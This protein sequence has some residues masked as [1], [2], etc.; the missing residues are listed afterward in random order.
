MRYVAH[1]GVKLQ[2]DAPAYE[3]GKW[4]TIKSLEKIEYKWRLNANL[5]YEVIAGVFCNKDDALKCAK[6][7]YVTLLY[8]MLKGQIPVAEAGCEIFYEPRFYNADRDGSFDAYEKTENFFFWDSHLIGGQLGPGVYEVEESI[9]D[10]DKYKFLDVGIS[11]S[12]PD[13]VLSFDNV[14][15]YTF[16]YC[17]Q[18]QQLLSTVMTADKIGDYGMKMTL[19][20]GLLEHL[21][22]DSDKSDT[23]KAEIDALISHVESS[24]LSKPE[25]EQTINFLRIGKSISAR[26]KCL[27]LLKRYAR[28]TYGDYSSKKV[29]DEAYSLRSRFSH[30]SEIEDIQIG[31]SRYMKYVVL[32][33]IKSYILEKE[34]FNV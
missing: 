32:D 14:D 26:Q 23:V 21:S 27:S 33:V 17:R 3:K 12:R 6:Q 4:K 9:E 7:V 20:C 13:M 8:S 11:I 5:L 2:Q 16:T 31:T 34:Q 19:Y 10:F 28:E 1:V 24:D 25:K 18:A 30:G 29:F 22:K 15:D